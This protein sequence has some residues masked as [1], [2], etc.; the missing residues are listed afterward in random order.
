MT[1]REATQIA[2][3]AIEE[4]HEARI[5]FGDEGDEGYGGHVMGAIDCGCELGRAYRTLT[6]KVRRAK[7]EE[8]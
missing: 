3:D 8:Q 4:A 6:R 7:K 2:I 5:G 1:V